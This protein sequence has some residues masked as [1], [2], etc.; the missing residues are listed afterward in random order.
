[1]KCSR[2]VG[3]LPHIAFVTEIADKTYYADGLPT[4]QTVLERLIG[5]Q[6]GKIDPQNSAAMQG[7]SSATALLQRQFN[8]RMVGNSDRSQFE[9]LMKLGREASEQGD[10]RQATIYYRDALK[11]QESLVGPNNVD[12]AYPLMNLGITLSNGQRFAE[13]NQVLDRAALLIR[14]VTD[15]ICRPC[16]KFTKPL[17][18]PISINILR[19]RPLPRRPIQCLSNWPRLMAI[20]RLKEPPSFS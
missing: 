15:P 8:G 16:L 11:L 10:F 13:A 1:M 5:I 9:K 2:K 7:Q 4:S 3:G 17:M 20:N 12:S 14:K 18:P 19:P 6:S